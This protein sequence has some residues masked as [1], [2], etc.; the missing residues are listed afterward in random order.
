MLEKKAPSV[1]NPKRRRKFLE[2]SRLIHHVKEKKEGLPENILYTSR[3]LRVARS[4]V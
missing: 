1:V 3:D 2:S 4:E